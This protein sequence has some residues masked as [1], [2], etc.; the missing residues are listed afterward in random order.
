MMVNADGYFNVM[1]FG[2]KAKP[3]GDDT[4]AIKAAGRHSQ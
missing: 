2:A 1:D 3:Y 4:A